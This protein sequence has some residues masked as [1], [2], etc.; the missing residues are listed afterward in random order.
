MSLIFF[1]PN[2]IFGGFDDEDFFND[3]TFIPPT[4]TLT[5]FSSPRYDV[6]E[7]E[8]QFQLSVDVPGVKPENVKIELEH[9]G[10]VL[11]ISGER[12][13]K[14][15]TDTSTSYEEYTFD[16]RFTIGKKNLDTTKFTAHLA[17]GVL[18]LT[19][20]KVEKLPP[21]TNTIA[22]TAG[23]APKLMDDEETTKKDD[24]KPHAQ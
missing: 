14:T 18:T 24:T 20:P 3:R 22:I 8:K 2:T 17:D 1:N 23:E 21:A 5:N 15:K 19:A 12:K 6:T 4:T 7:N 9:D 16:K 11:H 13:D 10:R